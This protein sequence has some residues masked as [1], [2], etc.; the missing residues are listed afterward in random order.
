[1]ARDD[2]ADPDR[3]PGDHLRHEQDGQQNGPQRQRGKDAGGNGRQGRDTIRVDGRVIR[4][5]HVSREGRHPPK[6]NLKRISVR[7]VAKIRFCPILEGLTTA[8]R[9]VSPL[10]RRRRTP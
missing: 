6:C 2:E 9:S 10:D 7:W 1:V 8:D 5:H 4:G 3:E